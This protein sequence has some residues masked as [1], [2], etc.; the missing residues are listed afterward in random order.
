MLIKNI[1]FSIILLVTCLGLVSAKLKCYS[2]SGMATSNMGILCSD[3]KG[4]LKVDCDDDA[5]G[6]FGFLNN[7]TTLDFGCGNQEK[8]A[9]YKNCCDT[10]YC[11][12]KDPKN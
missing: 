5:A 7:Q 6:C 2:A 4:L 11:N 10:D 1:T 12:C 3:I 9:K 8:C